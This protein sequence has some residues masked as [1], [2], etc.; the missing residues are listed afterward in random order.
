[1]AKQYA[2]LSRARKLGEQRD[3]IRIPDFFSDEGRTLL[4]RRREIE[5]EFDTALDTG[6]YTAV[7]PPQRQP[8]PLAVPAVLIASMILPLQACRRWWRT[9]R[10]TKLGCCTGCGYDLRAT[11]DRCP[12]CGMIPT[13]VKP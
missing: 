3:S 4:A 10:L 2:A 13:K 1:M 7:P 8:F 6:L 11:P 9:M 12:E 5:A